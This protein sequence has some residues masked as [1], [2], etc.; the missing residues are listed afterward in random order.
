MAGTSVLL[1]N[2]KRIL[3]TLD[4]R[5]KLVFV[6]VSGALAIGLVI[7]SGVYVFARYQL[8]QHTTRLLQAWALLERRD[9][10]LR[11]GNALVQAEAISSSTVTANALADS[12]GR[13]TYL[14][15]LL[16]NQKLGLEGA[17]L[18]VVDFR[19]QVVASSG[20]TSLSYMQDEGFAQMLRREQAQARVDSGGPH[21]ASL[22]VVFPI[23]YR[24]TGNIEGG[25][26]LQ[27]PL[28]PLLGISDEVDTRGLALPGGQIVA[29]ASPRAG[30]VVFSEPL[31]LPDP[32]GRL[33]LSLVLA[34]EKGKAYHDLNYVLAGAILFGGIVLGFLMLFARW[35]AGFVTAS[36]HE[37][38]CAA[39]QIAQ[40]G[41]PVA[42]LSIGG[43]DEFGRMA[44]AFNTMVERLQVSYAELEARV[45]ERTRDL[46]ASRQDAEKA[47]NLLREAVTSIAQGFTIYDEQDRLVLCNEAYLEF[48][49]DSRDLI[50]PGALFEDIVRIGAER[51][52]YV[53]AVG[54][55]DEWVKER[56]ARHQQANGEVFEQ[57]LAD[58]R[59]LLIVEHRTPSGFIVG[60]RI[61]ISARRNAENRLRDRTEQLNA[62]FALSPDGFVSF[63]RSGRV[64]Y[65]SPAFFLMTGFEESIVMGLNEQQFSDV[66]G[67]ACI[68]QVCFPG[69]DVLR[70][71][72]DVER[73]DGNAGKKRRQIIE[74]AGAGKR[75]LEVGFR[76]SE[77]ESVSQ[78]L[79]F[80]DVTHES[81]VDRMKSEFLSTAAHELRTP[82]A[83]IYGFSELMLNQ[84]FSPEQ[85]REFLSAIHSQAELMAAIVNELLDLARIEARRGKDFKIER[86]SVQELLRQFLGNFKAPLNRSSPVTLLPP[87]EVFL[88]GDRKKMT[89]AI[90][91]VISNAYKYSPEGGEVALGIAQEKTT[92]R[93]GISVSDQGIGM[94]P[95]QLQ[96]VC[97][98]FF[99]AD[100]S[101]AIPGTGLGMSIVKE[102][103]ELHGGEVEILSRYGEG[104][105]VVLW[106]PV[107][108]ELPVGVQD[109]AVGE[110]AAM[111]P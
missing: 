68:E 104:T 84:D 17:I 88:R 60:N 69:I 3:R 59:W 83:S 54:R 26:V 7:T 91:N 55:V 81:E 25:L 90:G 58:G 43:R 105:T 89:Q 9:L 95:A 97:E 23:R 18:S 53:E 102:I 12:V 66:L 50:L 63:D 33:D 36:L 92:G 37:T 28:Q 20:D 75:V 110:G 78:I 74:L 49:N 38:V 4:L 42:R 106:I 52:Q 39:E 76:R 65:A 100:T 8:G 56:V 1:E 94:T 21:Q 22:I 109:I 46:E 96:R 98:R 32:V 44:S 48:Y 45:T 5:G 111:V 16:R 51:G 57:Q 40:A 24:L 13:E 14:V 99:R 19:G 71:L 27:M 82:M 10:E 30:D 72:D 73:Q 87:Q 15:P 93:V 101:G 29:G 62:I 103:I 6:L 41:R 67:K 107:A 108:A 35:V 79:Y 77:A 31:A 61:D 85:T 64:K 80:R 47:G 34:L 2:V 86:L 11:V 70:G